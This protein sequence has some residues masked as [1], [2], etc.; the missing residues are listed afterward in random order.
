M[1]RFLLSRQW[2]MLTLVALLLIPVMVRLGFWQLHRHEQKVAHNQQIERALARPAVPVQRLTAPGRAVAEKDRYRRVT[3]TG[4]YDST[5]E[6][7]VRQRTGA[8]ERIGFHVLTPLVGSDGTVTLVNRG[9]VPPGEDPADYPEVPKAPTGRVTVTGL[10][11]PDETTASTGIKDR[12][13][14]PDRQIMLINGDKLDLDRPVRGGYVQLTRTSP[15]PSGEQPEPLPEPDHGSIGPHLAYAFNWWLLA[16]G[17]PIGWVV[18]FRRERRDR[19]AQHSPGTARS[20][21]AGEP[22]GTEQAE[23]APV[24]PERAGER[25]TGGGEGRTGASPPGGRAE[26]DAEDAPD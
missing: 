10:L 20:L 5:H 24:E 11:Q 25:D 9:W 2:V 18:L 22:A 19:L 12:R 3:V 16:A 8:E 14:L 4:R 7:V 21:R 13:G 6:V 1:Y 26:G 15:K 23:P 17:V